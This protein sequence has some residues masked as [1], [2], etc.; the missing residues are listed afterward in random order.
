[1]LLSLTDVKKTY[2]TPGYGERREVLK[3]IT[4]DLEER[5]TLAVTGPS[6]SG[7][8]TLLHLIG[9][10][11]SA[12]AGE[13]KF[14]D[15]TVAAMGEAERDRFRNREIGFVF[16]L[17]YLLPQHTLLDNVLLPALPG[18][19][20]GDWPEIEKR[21][22]RLLERTGLKGFE[23]ALP[24]ELSGGERQRAAL[25]RA[26]VNSPSLLLAD[27]PTGSLDRDTALSVAGLLR[28]LNREENTALVVVTHS[29]ELA[30]GLDRVR[31]LENGLLKP[32]GPR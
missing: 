15:K 23:R 19:R 30:R 29:D 5:G 12:D 10:L 21:A 8:S 18:A 25:A 2:L 24:G 13:I 11:D 32:L 16:Q 17:H 22:R 9:L 27:E 3:G 26:L 7:K 14:K 28:E 6:G 31:R 4:F 20:R 1:M